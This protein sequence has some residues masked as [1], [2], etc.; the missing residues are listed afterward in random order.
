MRV[1][2]HR[3][4]MRFGADKSIKVTC[5]Y[6]VTWLCTCLYGPPAGCEW[7]SLFLSPNLTLIT[8]RRA[9][10]AELQ[11]L[12][13]S[14][15]YH[16]LANIKLQLKPQSKVHTLPPEEVFALSGQLKCFSN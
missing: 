9:G 16:H 10:G 12:P 14:S 8:D 11:K 6:Q 4:L 5:R 7:S 3:K 15:Q 2:V 13:S 1:S